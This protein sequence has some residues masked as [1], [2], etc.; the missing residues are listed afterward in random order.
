MKPSAT[1]SR[2]PI[3]PALFFLLLAPVYLGAWG[4]FGLKVPA[5]L[6]LSLL[7]G[8]ALRILSAASPKA[9]PWQYF[10]VFPLFVPLSLPLWLVPT[11]LVAGWLISVSAFGGVGRNIFNP[12]AS[13]LVFLVAGYASSVALVAAKPF[14]GPLS[15][16]SR[17]TAGINPIE[18]AL[19]IWLSR[20]IT[21]L[22]EV[23]AGGHLPSL[24]GLA[25]PGFLLLSVLLVV[26]F[27]PGRRL[28]LAAVLFFSIFT[29]AALQMRFVG[30]MAGPL[31]LPLTG[32]FPALLLLALADENTIPEPAFEQFLFG[33]VLGPLL[34][35]FMLLS[36][37]ELAPVFALLLAQA[38]FP[39]LRDLSGGRA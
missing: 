2:L 29:A 17:W 7:T 26:L 36:R 4:R 38:L 15:A 9:F 33:M 32:I 19:K 3:G 10:W 5:A 27:V 16:F 24:P 20:P 39:L 35:L 25:F 8:L 13:S 21:G 37:T 28:W 11:V 6:L 1:N 31:S 30:L 34:A 14:P 12:P 23:F 22:G 18:P